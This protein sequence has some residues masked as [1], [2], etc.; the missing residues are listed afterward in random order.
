MMM[1]FSSLAWNNIGYINWE[2]WLPQVREDLPLLLAH[3]CLLDLHTITSWIFSSDRKDAGIL[4]GLFVF[5]YHFIE[6]DYFDDWQ[7]KFIVGLSPRF[8][9]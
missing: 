6:M 9:I 3:L 4:S 8:A 5:L 7:W 2:P 1:I